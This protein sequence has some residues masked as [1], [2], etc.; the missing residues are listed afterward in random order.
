VR[1]IGHADAVGR[2][3]ANQALGQ[4]RADSVQAFLV[5][6]GIPVEAIRTES[7][8]QTDPA[9]NTRKP[10]PR[11]RRVEVRFE[12]SSLLTKFLPGVSLGIDSQDQAGPDG[13]SQVPWPMV[14]PAGKPFDELW[15]DI[16]RAPR[17][18]DRF[19]DLSKAYKV[20][21]P[22]V[23]PVTSDVPVPELGGA[24]G[25]HVIGGDVLGAGRAGKVLLDKPKKQ[26]THPTGLASPAEAVI[27]TIEKNALLPATVKGTKVEPDTWVGRAPAGGKEL[28]SARFEPQL[29]AEVT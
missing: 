21:E 15:P 8:G 16:P 1:L 26:V 24:A 22:E 2:E 4:N 29:F 23:P 10:E 11:N 20:G 9:V 18:P 7:R 14:D 19:G 12:P 5:K 6:A 17:K 27:E 25:T 28:C 13:G 3:E